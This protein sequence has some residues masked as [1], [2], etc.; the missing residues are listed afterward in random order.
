MSA[1]YGYMYISVCVCWCQKKKK[2]ILLKQN[3]KKFCKYLFIF[4][5]FIYLFSFLKSNVQHRNVT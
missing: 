2:D 1:F 3:E 5:I 4:R